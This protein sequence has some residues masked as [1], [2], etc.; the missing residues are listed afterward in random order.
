MGHVNEYPTM[1]Y[2][3][4]LRNTQSM[5][6]YMIL[7]ECFR[8]EFPVKNCIVGMLLT[9]PIDYNYHPGFLLTYIIVCLLL[10]FVISSQYYYRKKHQSKEYH[11]VKCEFVSNSKAA[12]R[13]HRQLHASGSFMCEICGK[14]FAL[15]DSLQKH[16]NVRSHRVSL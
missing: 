13:M 2:F 7:T 9:C 5:I 11:C 16:K 4:N 15:R 12:I 3:G 1:L 10:R 6:A 8:Q 14:A